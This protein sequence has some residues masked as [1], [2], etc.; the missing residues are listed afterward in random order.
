[1]SVNVLYTTRAT[2]NGGR[3]GVSFGGSVAISVCG[4]LMFSGSAICGPQEHRKL[5]IRKPSR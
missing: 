2:S 4:F 5:T 1:M 3:G